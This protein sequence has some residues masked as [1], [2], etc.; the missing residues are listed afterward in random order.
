MPQ[1]WRAGCTWPRP[2]QPALG[3]SVLG[4]GCG[5]RRRLGREPHFF[6]ANATAKPTECAGCCP[7]GRARGRC[8]HQARVHPAGPVGLSSGR[9]LGR[10]PCSSRL[11]EG[12][13]EHWTEVAG[14]QA[15]RASLGCTPSPSLTPVIPYALGITWV[16]AS[17][18]LRSDRP[19]AG[20]GRGGWRAGRDPQ[21]Q[22]A[23]SGFFQLGTRRGR[24][25]VSGA[26]KP[27]SPWA[28]AG[29]GAGPPRPCVSGE[30]RMGPGR[31]RV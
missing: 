8:A 16:S 2:S 4:R 10:A 14:N 20:A 3:P 23:F 30:G 28:V 22:F 7:A 31:R 15:S 26:S 17:R 6:G 25:A 18:L 27:K 5:P 19:G 9:W 29:G 1:G 21:G 11:G 13:C 24:G 12:R